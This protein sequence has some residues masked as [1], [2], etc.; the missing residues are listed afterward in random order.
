MLLKCSIYVSSSLVILI[1]QICLDIYGLVSH[2][3]AP[4]LIKSRKMNRINV[5]SE[6]NGTVKTIKNVLKRFKTFINVFTERFKTYKK[7]CWVYKQLDISRMIMA[8]KCFQKQENHD[9]NHWIYQN[10]AGRTLVFWYCKM[11]KTPFLPVFYRSVYT[12]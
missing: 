10:T 3:L 5:K 1:C 6:W 9:K 11:A 8:C 2:P 12:E 7:L 4:R